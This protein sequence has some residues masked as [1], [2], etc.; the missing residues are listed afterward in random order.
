MFY[1]YKHVND[2]L[3]LLK[4]LHIYNFRDIKGDISTAKLDCTCLM[5]ILKYVYLI[6]I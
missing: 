4:S 6:V 1:K 5:S 2:M 3:I